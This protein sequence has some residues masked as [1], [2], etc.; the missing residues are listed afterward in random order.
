M[1]FD[2]AYQQTKQEYAQ[3]NIKV[4]SATHYIHHM[5]NTLMLTFV[6]IS[7]PNRIRS[8]GHAD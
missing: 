7:L 6:K 8:P 3:P 5:Y 1:L 4:F 2:C